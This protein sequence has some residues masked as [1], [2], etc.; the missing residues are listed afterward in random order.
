MK[1]KIIRFLHHFRTKIAFFILGFGSLVWFLIRVIP[2][3]SRAAYPCMKAAAPLASSF[4]TYLLGITS[5]TFFFRK[6][7]ERL[8]RSKYLLASAFIVLGL[9][10]GAWIIISTNT[11]ALA[12]DNDPQPPQ[13]SN[14]PIGV[15]KGIFPGRVVWIHNPY[16]TD[17]NC[18]NGSGDYWYMDAN[19]DQEVVNDML[20]SGLQQ[21]TGTTT[22]AVAWDSIFHYY[23]RNRGNGNNG[24]QAGEKI[25]IKINLNGINNSFPDRNV[26]TSPQ[27]CYAILDQLVNVV[28]VAE[29]DISIGD[30]NCSMNQCTYTKCHDT[31][32]DVTYWGAGAGL[33][34][35]TPSSYPVLYASDGSYSDKLPQA[36]LDASYLINIPVFKKH[37]RA[38]ISLCCKNHFGSIGAYTSGAW[39]LHPSLPAPET[40]DVTNGNYGVYRCFVDIMGHKDLG[41]K[42]ILYLVDGLWGSVN[43]GHPPVKWHMTPFNDDWPSSLFLSQDPVAIES[44]GYDFLYYEFDPDQSET[45]HPEEGGTWSDN[46]GPF[47]HFQGTDDYLHQAADPANWPGGI[48]Y[49]PENDG[50][51]LTSM[52]THEHWNNAVDKQYSRNLGTGDGIE[53]FSPYVE[54]PDALNHISYIPEGFE[55]KQNTPNPFSESTTLHFRIAVPSNIQL[56]IFATN[57][58]LI[59]TISFAD[60]ISGDYNC[61]WDGTN[62][63]GVPVPAGSYICNLSVTN[64]RGY[65]EMSNK[66]QVMR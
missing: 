37:H 47:P 57:G 28:G 61:L 14:E 39:H 56:R 58:Q 18:T 9:V 31:F 10:A 4:V 66:M 50:S 44:V 7:R 62:E 23:N 36:Y 16:A 33:T 30:P 53:L 46:S 3:P 63:A 32:A 26:N 60:R 45:E 38:G 12:A 65:F 13:A 35:A 8:I 41:G 17:E 29:T 6:A 51:L 52:G 11:S 1:T 20:S 54:N 59:K 2:K 5:F 21:L 49:D 42:T 34:Y 24:Y 55:L 64:H 40:S 43:W 27:I 22:D 19:T 15:G 48:D 25:A